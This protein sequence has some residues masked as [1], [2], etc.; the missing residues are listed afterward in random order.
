[1]IY[2]Q[3]AAYTEPEQFLKNNNNMMQLHKCLNPDYRFR[4]ITEEDEK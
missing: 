4:F 1:M 2:P 3:P